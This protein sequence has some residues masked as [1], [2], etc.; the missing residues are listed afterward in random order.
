MIDIKPTSV[1]LEA[2]A[3]SIKL[4]PFWTDKPEIWFFQLE[5]RFLENV[6]DIIKDPANTARYSTVKE[7]LLQTFQESENVRIKRL[8]TGLEFGDML[9]SQS[10]ERCV[11]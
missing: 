8:L 11:P 6:W 3:I 9:P 10:Y 5:T 4:P 7:R 1:E 2:G